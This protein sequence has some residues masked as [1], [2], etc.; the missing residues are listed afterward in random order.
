V[1]ANVLR[2][3]L[4]AAFVAVPAAAASLQAHAQTGTEGQLQRDF[5]AAFSRMLEDPANLDKTFRYAELAVQVGDF[6][7]AISALERMLLYNPNLPRVRL[8]LGVLYFRLGSY[9]IAR[10]YLTRAVEGE[11][12]PDDVRARVAVFL[13]EIDKR[14]SK[15]RFAASMY[16]GLRYQ[17]NANA[18]P[19]NQTITLLGATATLNSRFTKKNDWNAFVSGTLRHTYDPQLQSGEVMET[20]LLLYGSRQFEQRQLDLVFAEL[21]TGPR[22]RFLREYLETTTWRPYVVGSMVNLDQSP[23]FYSYGIGSS[24]DATVAEAT[25][26]TLDVSARDRAFRADA[27]RPTARNQSG[28]EYQATTDLRY[29]ASDTLLLSGTLGWREISARQSLH[30]NREWEFG[31]GLTMT[32]PGPAGDAAPPWTSTL[33]GSYIETQYFAPDPAVDPNRV[34]RDSEWRGTL[35]TTI[36]LTRDWALIATLQRTVVGSNFKNFTYTNNAASIGASVR[37]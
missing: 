28:Q 9:A 12:V 31:V 11:N 4:L 8:E 17:S 5:E 13:D 7:A 3:A 29:Q 33:S 14:L 26:G 1:I 21:K 22:A 35:L 6:E 24:F 16:G 23:Y 32:H 34:R 37:F 15:H 18:G 27:G 30:S 36:P 25:T 10:T 19:T 20:E 2:K